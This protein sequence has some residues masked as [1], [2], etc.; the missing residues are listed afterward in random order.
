MGN[1][2]VTEA[3]RKS[4]ELIVSHLREAFPLDGILS[5]EEID[6]D[7]RLFTKRVWMI[8]PIDGTQG[9]VDKKGDFAV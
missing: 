2:I 4:S 1:K 7:E 9:F 3:D 8:D 6:T 5:E